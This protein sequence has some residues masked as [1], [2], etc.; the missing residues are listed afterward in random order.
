MS[1]L[2]TFIHKRTHYPGYCCHYISMYCMLTELVDVCIQGYSQ[3][4]IWLYR[5]H[6]PCLANTVREPL[7]SHL[8]RRFSP[9]HNYTRKAWEGTKKNG[10]LN[11]LIMAWRWCLC[12][13]IYRRDLFRHFRR[14]EVEGKWE[15]VL[16]CGFFPNI[17][18]M[19]LQSSNGFVSEWE[20]CWGKW[21]KCHR[22][23][24][25]MSSFKQWATN[26]PKMS[27][28]PDSSLI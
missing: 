3:A 21:L 11:G 10:S 28:T 22:K 6:H 20:G 24:N 12:F 4:H 19:S 2:I 26:Q 5:V 1:F 17:S 14:N 18:T 15:M 27:I 9:S 25:G 23:A 16:R 7:L 13:H 8:W